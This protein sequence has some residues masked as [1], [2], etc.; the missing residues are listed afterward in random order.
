[1]VKEESYYYGWYI[2]TLI[3]LV[4]GLDNIFDLNFLNGAN[5]ISIEWILTWILI[6]YM[7]LTIAK[8]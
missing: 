7:G 4:V 2:L 3:F 5:N 1:M 6:S 8:K